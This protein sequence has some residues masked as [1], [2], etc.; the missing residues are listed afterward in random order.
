M[1]Q[2]VDIERFVVSFEQ[3]LQAR[4]RMHLHFEVAVLI[5]LITLRG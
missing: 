4:H 3:D 2:S 5:L 1:P